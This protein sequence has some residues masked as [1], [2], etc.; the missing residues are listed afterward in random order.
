MTRKK[1][2]L[3]TGATS[4][5]GKY[6]AGQLRSSHDL[7]IVGRDPKKMESYFPNSDKYQADLSSLA[8]VKKAAEQIAAEHESIDLLICNAGILGSENFTKTKEGIEKTLAVNYLSHYT[9][10][11]RLWDKF[12]T[13][14]S[15][16]L[17]VGSSAAAWYKV[18]F[19][20]PES[21]SDYKSL[22]AYGR[23]KAML[24]MLGQWI[25]TNSSTSRPK[26][27]VFDP[28]TFRSGIARNR[29]QWFQYMYKLAGWAM[30]E[31][32]RAGLEMLNLVGGA[33]YPAGKIIKKGKVKDLSFS[34]EEISN[35]MEMSRTMTG[36]DINGKR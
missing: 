34:T 10:L 32:E 33:D 14:S 3:I 21:K 15:A 6:L 16:V 26:S 7:L 4:G 27:Y 9:L 29:G 17:M 8:E 20:D 35:L 36:C 25:H 31:A 22:K 1:K 18:D 23:T 2:I 5:L 30:T 24:M 19:S 28:G 12:S 13:D 11:A